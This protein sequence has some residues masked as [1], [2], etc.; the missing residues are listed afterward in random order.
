MKKIYTLIILQL[1]LT[2]LFSQNQFVQYSTQEYY[3]KI[4]QISKKSD[5]SYSLPLQVNISE[6]LPF[7]LSNSAEI[8]SVV[9]PFYTSSSEIL[10]SIYRITLTDKS[11]QNKFINDIKNS[12][13]V[14]Y[15]EPVPIFKTIYTPNDPEFHLFTIW[16]N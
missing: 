9:R 11:N 5:K 3:I 1:V 12:K 10:Q 2:N 15:I 8:K 13:D 6:E 14:E 7:L 4:K 16:I